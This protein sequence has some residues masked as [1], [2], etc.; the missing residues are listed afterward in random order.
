[1]K[2][3]RKEPDQGGKIMNESTKER[4]TS[5]LKTI[6]MGG[7]KIAWFISKGIMSYFI[8]SIPAMAMGWRR[9]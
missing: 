9:H 1:M 7:L 5:I 4:T 2:R 3:S 6:M 8:L